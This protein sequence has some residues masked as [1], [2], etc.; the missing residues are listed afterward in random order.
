M[1][2]YF[3]SGLLGDLA[4]KANGVAE[5]QLTGWAS[6]PWAPASFPHQVSKDTLGLALQDG[7]VGLVGVLHGDSLRELA[8]HPLLEGLQPLV[9]VPSTDELLV[10]EAK[11]EGNEDCPSQRR[12]RG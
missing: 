8:E 11:R 2:T 4:Y 3:G 1:R 10:L 6:P 7:V 5:T 9:V 12:A